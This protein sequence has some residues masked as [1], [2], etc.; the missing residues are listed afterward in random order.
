MPYTEPPQDWY[1]NWMED[2]KKRKKEDER[3]EAARRAAQ[4][5]LKILGTSKRLCELLLELTQLESLIKEAK[6][7]SAEYN[8]AL[9]NASSLDDIAVEEILEINVTLNTLRR[10][11]E[12]RVNEYRSLCK[13]LKKLDENEWQQAKD[14]LRDWLVKENKI[15]SERQAQHSKTSQGATHPSA[16]Q[17]TG[18]KATSP[19]R[20]QYSSSAQ[21]RK[22]DPAAKPFVPRTEYADDSF[23]SSDHW[24]G[25]T[26]EDEQC[27]YEE[28]TSDGAYELYDAQDNFSNSGPAFSDAD[29]D[30]SVSGYSSDH[31]GSKSADDGCNPAY[32]NDNERCRA[33]HVKHRDVEGEFWDFA[34]GIDRCCLC[35]REC[36]G[37]QCPEFETC[38]FLAC[39]FCKTRGY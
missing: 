32:K 39:Q 29:R 3:R 1:K 9:K 21:K 4:D 33:K 35:G 22:F 30:T 31:G 24:N 7:L 37:L 5:Q 17:Y 14:R 18:N 26:K 23:S 8:A 19:T 10:E 38:G 20:A 28:E 11:R 6:V 27:K 12:T 25:C 13:K 16:Q 34:P 15:N 2:E 36:T